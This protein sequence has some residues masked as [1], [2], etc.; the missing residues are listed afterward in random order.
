MSVALGADRLPARP[1]QV[2]DR[3]QGIDFAWNGRGHRGYSGDTI[4]S[5]LYAAGVRVYS[6][7]F[8]YHRP[9][10]LLCVSGRCPNCLCNVDGT[11]NVRICTTELQPGMQV[12]SQNAWPSVDRDVMSVIDTLS[13]LLPVGF[14]YK[15]FIQPKGMWPLYEGVLRRAAGL[16]V[17]DTRREPQGDYVTEYRHTD[18]AVVGGGPAGLAAALEAARLGA[19]VTLIDDQPALGGSL[20]LDG[21]AE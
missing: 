3:S 15:T 7:S 5:A 20:R 10:G 6:R 16:G 19:D 9:R 2:L 12:R 17:L 8:K 18:V 14:Y 11:P 13:P 4:A 1:G 21:G